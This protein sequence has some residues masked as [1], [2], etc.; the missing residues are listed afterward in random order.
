[1]KKDIKQK[2]IEEY[3]PMTDD[4]QKILQSAAVKMNLSARSYFRL[5]KVARTIADLDSS[6][7]LKVNHIAE[8]LQYRIADGSL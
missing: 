3:C 7:E 2:N 1:M 4:A 8:A 6:D 5:I